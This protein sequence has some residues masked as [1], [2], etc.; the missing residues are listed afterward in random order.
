MLH[1]LRVFPKFFE[2]SGY[3]LRVGTYSRNWNNFGFRKNKLNY[4]NYAFVNLWV[5]LSIHLQQLALQR[6]LLV[7]LR[8]ENLSKREPYNHHNIGKI[9][10]LTF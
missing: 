5:S 8:I 4:D 2:N 3:I 9:Q 7:L 10:F 6:T 1:A